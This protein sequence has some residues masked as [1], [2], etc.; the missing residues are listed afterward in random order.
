MWQQLLHP[1]AGKNTVFALQT[2]RNQ[3]QED[4]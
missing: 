2:K 3:D 4:F 1:Y